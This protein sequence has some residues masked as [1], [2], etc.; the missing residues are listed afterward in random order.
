MTQW[1]NEAAIAQWD[2]ATGRDLMQATADEGDLAKRHLVNEAVFRLIGD[3]SGLRVLDAGCGNGY[4]SRMLA[5]RA[6]TSS[7][8]SRPAL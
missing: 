7:G 1:T 5:Q 4:L 3:V 2:A 6:R 8:S